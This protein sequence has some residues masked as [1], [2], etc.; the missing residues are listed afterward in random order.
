MR[1][2]ANYIICACR[3]TAT[4]SHIIWRPQLTYEILNVY[5]LPAFSPSWHR[6]KAQRVRPG[7]T[8]FLHEARKLLRMIMHHG[9]F[10]NHNH[11]IQIQRKFF[12]EQNVGHHIHPIEPSLRSHWLCA[13][14]ASAIIISLLPSA[15]NSYPYTPKLKLES[16][17]HRRMLKP[18]LNLEKTIISPLRSDFFWSQKLYKYNSDRTI[19]CLPTHMQIKTSPARQSQL[20]SHSCTQYVLTTDHF[21]LRPRNGIGGWPSIRWKFTLDWAWGRSYRDEYS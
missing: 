11:L 15:E 19:H 3:T 21:G 6:R 12:A 17:L 7:V 9:S 1:V 13:E 14:N 2:T 18:S 5:R 10:V 16:D 8:S 4:S 20:G